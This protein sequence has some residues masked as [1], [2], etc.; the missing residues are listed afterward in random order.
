VRLTLELTGIVSWQL[1]EMFPDEME[2]LMPGGL[3]VTVPL[4]VPSPETLRITSGGLKD[5]VTDV[6]AEIV[7][8]HVGVVPQAPPQPA[9]EWPLTEVLAVS[10]M[11]VLPSNLA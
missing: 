5:A 4:P 2:Q 6:S 3:L 9:K 10:V 8:R 1:P 11:E 7:T